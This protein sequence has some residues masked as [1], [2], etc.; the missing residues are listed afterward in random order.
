MSQQN[1]QQS[2]MDGKDSKNT[3]L[4]ESN[5]RPV[6]DFKNQV[7][8]N[9]R[10]KGVQQYVEVL[11]DIVHE[12]IKVQEKEFICVL[13]HLFEIHIK[14][15]MYKKMELLDK[16]RYDRQIA[17]ARHIFQTLVCIKL[18]DFSETH[19]TEA[20]ELKLDA[21]ILQDSEV[22]KTFYKQAVDNNSV[23]AKVG[24]YHF[25]LHSLLN[26]IDNLVEHTESVSIIKFYRDVIQSKFKENPY[27]LVFE[28]S[29]TLVLDILQQTALTIKNPAVVENKE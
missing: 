28:A 15:E 24:H 27:D 22:C 1:N 10:E 3:T 8:D 13:Y 7:E 21:L 5:S 2:R 18:T 11:M 9:S 14:Y 20:R 19:F 12:T 23:K 25:M 29:L 26:V 17:I 16:P 6:I 4:T